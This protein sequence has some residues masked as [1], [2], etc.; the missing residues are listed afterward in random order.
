MEEMFSKVKHYY[1][2]NFSTFYVHKNS[3]GV[4][5][6]HE[7]EIAYVNKNDVESKIHK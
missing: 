5:N 6:I 4:R 3:R 2:A 7:I 1:H